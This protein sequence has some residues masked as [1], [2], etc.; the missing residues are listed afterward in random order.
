MKRVRRRSR[1]GGFRRARSFVRKVVS[2][3][4]PVEAKR[5]VLDG[6]SIP[7]KTAANYDNPV[8]ISLLVC[9][10]SVDEELESDGTNVAQVPLYSKI[11]GFKFNGYIQGPVADA[12]N[13]RWML[14]KDEDG[15][16]PVTSLA[17]GFFHSS[18]D[19]ATLREL[20]A[21]TLAKGMIHLNQSQGSTRLNLFIRRS[22]LKRLGSLRENDR[23]RLLLAIDGSPA[24]Q[25]AV[26]GFGALY[27]RLN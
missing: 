22:T 14:Y 25:P 5:I 8:T 13:C 10:E 27:C 19:T 18:N 12:L 24:T 2:K 7:D 15:E 20:R 9:Q 17:D 1:R 11:V 26:Y 3:M 16:A 4:G 6:I 23:I 21:R